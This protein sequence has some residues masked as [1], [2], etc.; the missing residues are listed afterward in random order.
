MAMPLAGLAGLFLHD[1]QVM[2]LMRSKLDRLSSP[3]DVEIK[4]RFMVH[5]ALYG[6]ATDRLYSLLD[7]D[8]SEREPLVGGGA[9]SPRRGSMIVTVSGG[10]GGG[11][12]A[13]S[14]SKAMMDGDGAQSVGG[15]GFTYEGGGGGGVG[16][17]GGG[18]GGGGSRGGMGAA[19]GDLEED[20]AAEFE[21]KVRGV[22]PR[23]VL[24]EIR[25]LYKAAVHKFRSSSILHV[26]F[27]R[28]YASLVGNRHM[29]LSH[30]L[31]AE[32]S[33]PSL[34]VSYVVYQARK[35][36]EDSG[37]AQLSAL[38]RVEFD[39]YL[40]DSRKNVQMA[41][42]RQLAFFAEL[43]N[44][45]PDLMRL[46]R[47]SS[48]MI[49][50]VGDSEKT[51]TQLFAMDPQSVVSIRLYSGFNEY[52]LCNSEKAALLASEAD[53]IDEHRVK[54]HQGEVKGGVQAF[55]SSSVLDVTGE[56]TA[57]ISILSTPRHFGLIKSTNSAA[58][59]LFGTLRLQLE[60]RS[61]FS[62]FPPP[63]ARFFES[64][65]THYVATGEGEL[66]TTRMA[67]GVH[68][69]GY[70][71]P[72]LVCMR[73]A[74]PTDAA[75]SFIIFCRPLSSPEQHIILKEDF[76]FAGASLSTCHLLRIDPASLPQL[77]LVS[78]HD[79]V[80][81]WEESLG[82][83][84]SH[85][86]KL[87]TIRPLKGAGGRGGGGGGSDRER[88]LTSRGGGPSSDEEDGGGGGWEDLDEEEGGGG[89]GGC[90]GG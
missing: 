53:R 86:G 50:A 7:N 88:T 45:L 8:L 75:P 33:M 23:E 2:R 77:G 90:C 32:R 11:G 18:G 1:Y 26:F 29:Q 85:A 84:R 72:L 61:V 52:V 25:H 62:L 49:Q 47:L 30:L 19:V 27:S 78:I 12:I 24:E 34:D 69:K 4:T 58:A 83:L 55:M 16:G 42:K 56:A 59:K 40:L 74:P 51:F 20:E 3:Y 66:S 68:R 57:I 14:S 71:F 41:A 76:T 46:H 70:T 54:E 60:R 28:F 31:Q 36:A 38:A 63:L 5:E 37:G 81:D 65:L 89:R 13:A 35:A 22:F 6:H 48:D 9:T 10:G 67:Y 17:G 73:E 64:V 43:V 39:K 82:E 44:P 21:A 79:V 87:I 15:G 80:E